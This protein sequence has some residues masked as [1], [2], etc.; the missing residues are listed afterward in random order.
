[1]RGQ[2]NRDEECGDT[3]PFAARRTLKDFFSRPGEDIPGLL[4][5]IT[6]M[7][8]ALDER[9]MTE[10]ARSMSYGDTEDTTHCP[11]A[12]V[13]GRHRSYVS[14]I[15]RQLPDKDHDIQVFGTVDEAR[16]WLA[17]QPERGAY[18]GSGDGRQPVAATKS[19]ATL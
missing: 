7:R 1:M 11:I 13:A 18:A 8:M 6:A 10:F 9:S 14:C 19:L 2:D 15:F 17:R 3:V 16:A 12:I 4:I 5:D